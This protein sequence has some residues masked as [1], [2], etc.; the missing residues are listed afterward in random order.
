MKGPWR[1][2]AGP[3]GTSGK[4]LDVRRVTFLRRAATYGVRKMSGDSVINLKVS[5]KEMEEVS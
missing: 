4:R 5:N 2:R 3:S 1:G